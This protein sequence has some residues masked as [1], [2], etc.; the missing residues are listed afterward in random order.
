MPPNC[1]STARDFNIFDVDEVLFFTS[2]TIFLLNCGDNF[3]GLPVSFL[4]PY[5]FGL[6]KKLQITVLL[7][8]KAF[9]ISLLDFLTHFRGVISPFSNSVNLV[10]LAIYV[11]SIVTGKLTKI[12]KRDFIFARVKT[13]QVGTWSPTEI[14]P[15]QSSLLRQIRTGILRE[16]II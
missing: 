15:V 10:P 6:F 12:P 11:F 4:V 1:S 9:E 3:S 5:L 8:P 2:R 16:G 13:G 14:S 7:H